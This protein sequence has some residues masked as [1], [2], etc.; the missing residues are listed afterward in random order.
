MLMAKGAALH[1]NQQ[2][3]ALKVQIFSIYLDKM[4]NVSFTV[5]KLAALLLGAV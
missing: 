3:Q 5:E 4:T 2:T 1:M